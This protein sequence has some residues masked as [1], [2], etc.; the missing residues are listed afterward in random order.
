[1]VETPKFLL[2]DER[3][4]E[5]LPEQLLYWRRAG[6]SYNAIARMLQ[7][8]TGVRLTRQTIRDWVVRIE[9]A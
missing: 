4:A 2:V 3:L 6:V 9:A 5:P 7:T 8:E 1:M